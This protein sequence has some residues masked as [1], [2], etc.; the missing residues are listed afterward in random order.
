FFLIVF[1]RKKQPV[2]LLLALVFFLGAGEEISWGQRIFHIRPP[3]YFQSKNVQHELNIHNLEIFNTNKLNGTQA[4]GLSLLLTFNFAY[5][6]FWLGFG[7]ILPLLV[8]GSRFVKK[9]AHAI[10]LP[11]PPLS[12]GLLFPVNWLIYRLAHSYL[13]PGG[14]APLYYFTIYEMHEYGAAFLFML[15][16]IYFLAQ[17]PRKPA[18]GP[19]PLAE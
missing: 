9:A 2:C 15:L 1:I 17:A 7:V 16:S 12:V 5:K 14:K 18:P 4:R 3:E 8:L 19:L 10:R 11:V 13:L 6:L